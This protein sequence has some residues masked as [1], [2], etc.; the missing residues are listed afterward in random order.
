ILFWTGS[1]LAEAPRPQTDFEA[2]WIMQGAEMP[3]MTAK[4]HYSVDL[5]MMRME[6]AHQDMPM[7]TIRN[8][9]TG[10]MVMWSAQM[11]GMAMRMNTPTEPD[12]AEPT[13]TGETRTIGDEDC[14]VVLVSDVEICLSTDN[15][16]LEVS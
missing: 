5:Q 15:I 12:D 7:T 6:M 13:P 1:A 9:A 11:P 10:E 2:D 3:D 14:D 16:A 4:M 8:M